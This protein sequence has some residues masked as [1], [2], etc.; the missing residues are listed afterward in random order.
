MKSISNINKENSDKNEFKSKAVA[1]SFSQQPVSLTN[2]PLL[3]PNGLEN[4][5]AGLY[6]IFLPYLT[7]IVFLFIFVSKG[8]IDIFQSLNS[9]SSFFFSWCIGYECLAGIIL[10]WIIKSAVLFSVQNKKTNKEFVRPGI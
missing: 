5:F 9:Q 3:F 4:V 6:F 1:T 2:S 7:G 8:S 10:L